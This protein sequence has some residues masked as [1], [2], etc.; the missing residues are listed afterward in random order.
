MAALRAA[1]VSVCGVSALRYLEPTTRRAWICRPRDADPWLF[2]GSLCYRREAWRRSPFPAVNRGEEVTF[3]SNFSPSQRCD[4]G[5]AWL[6]VGVLHT[7]NT[8]SR[9]F[10][11]S[12]LPLRY[13]V[14]A[15]GLAGDLDCIAT[16]V[17]SS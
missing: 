10:G 11:G 6:L 7:R 17:R 3:V 4:L 5:D 9:P 14:V 15:R 8:S 1:A 16:A 12:W 2:G 13:E